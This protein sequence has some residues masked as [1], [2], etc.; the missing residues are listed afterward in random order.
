MISYI[1][2]SELVA[3]T[4]KIQLSRHIRRLLTH[5]ENSNVVLGAL[6]D[7]VSVCLTT[8]LC[9]S[10]SRLSSP[11]YRASCIC[12]RLELLIV[13]QSVKLKETHLNRHP[14]VDYFTSRWCIYCC[15]VVALL[16]TFVIL[17]SNI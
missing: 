11:G 12:V 14:S 7:M 1:Q 15:S 13:T 9:P 5:L 10:A 3:L 6:V 8:T 4:L 2:A 17:E 16:V